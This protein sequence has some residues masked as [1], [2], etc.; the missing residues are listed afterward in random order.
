MAPGPLQGLKVILPTQEQF[1]IFR[2]EINLMHL[3]GTG[4]PPVERRQVRQP[5]MNGAID[6]GFRLLPRRMTLTLALGAGNLAHADVIRDRLTYIFSPSISPLTLE[7]TRDDLT[8]K[9]INC[10][11]IGDLDYPQSL[12]IGSGQTIIVPL[13]ANDPLFYSAVAYSNNI[14]LVDEVG[15]VLNIDNSGMTWDDFPIVEIEGPATNI[16]F[17]IY[18][19]PSIS[20]QLDE[21]LADNEVIRFDFRSG[22]KT[23]T[24]VS[25][26]ANLMDYINP[27][28]LPSFSDYRVFCPRNFKEANLGWANDYMQMSFYAEDITGDSKATVYWRKR[29]LT[30]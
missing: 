29:Y 30:L 10:H 1:D 4:M 12:R 21:D 13:I 16:I 18:P 24:R 5:M 11:V 19:A 2:G 7:I 20:I 15:V 26:G 14:S 28:Y 23:A 6:K 3:D 25:N 9:R 8:V 22:Y 27:L 17:S